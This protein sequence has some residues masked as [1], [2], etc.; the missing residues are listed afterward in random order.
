MTITGI[1]ERFATLDTRVPLAQYN[2]RHFRTVHLL[3]D[4]IRTLRTGGIQ[5]GELAPDF[6]LPRTFGGTLRLSETRERPVLL[7]FGSPT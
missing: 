5:P 4:A 1:G 7:R 6:E 3:R 2:Y